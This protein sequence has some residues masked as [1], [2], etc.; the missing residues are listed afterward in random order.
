MRAIRI[1]MSVLKKERKKNLPL[2]H[3]ESRLLHAERS[4]TFWS[5]NHFYSR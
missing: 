3:F 2:G 5:V 1:L 4:K